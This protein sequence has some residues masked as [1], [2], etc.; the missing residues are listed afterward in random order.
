M[1]GSPNGL[2]D[3]TEHD[4]FLRILKQ[5]KIE[6]R[7]LESLDRSRVVSVLSAHFTGKTIDEIND[8]I[9]FYMHY[10]S[11]LQ[12]KQELLRSWRVEQNA[13]R[14]TILESAVETETETAQGKHTKISA[15]ENL[16]RKQ[17]VLVWKEE[18]AALQRKKQVSFK[19]CSICHTIG[20]SLLTFAYLSG[21]G[22]GRITQ[23]Y[24][25]D[26]RYRTGNPFISSPC[27]CNSV[28]KILYIVFVT[29]S[30]QGAVDA[31][32]T[33]RLEGAEG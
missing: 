12:E 13:R 5:R 11:L 6:W 33:G 9:D 7:Q 27:A 16:E 17:K 21:S 14:K 25:E 28:S 19:L 26:C 8:H 4:I 15:E 22:R 1:L 2:W 18:Q 10:E 31:E 24:E 3:S 30:S 29:E 32:E 23:A 20:T